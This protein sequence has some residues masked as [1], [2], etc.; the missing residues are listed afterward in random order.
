MKKWEDYLYPNGVLKNKKGIEDF[1][2]LLAYEFAITQISNLQ[3]LYNPIK[4][5]IGFDL[6]KE[7]HN[8]LFCDIYD[9]A[10]KLRDVEIRK[11]VDEPFFT[12]TKLIKKKAEEIFYN[13]KRSNYFL[14][15][16]KEQFII[17]SAEL[18]A[19]LND[20]HPFREGNG[21]TNKL[22]LSY[23]AIINGYQFN[24]NEI[25]QN[26]WIKA[27]AT[28]HTLGDI[29]GLINLLK[30]SI[31]HINDVEYIDKFRK[32]LSLPSNI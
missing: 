2:L 7:M 10:G 22:F 8:Q 24:Y 6:L 30:I 20:L 14:G 4:S 16:S 21:R 15:N 11:S 23:I 3:L 27:S 5:N 18:L 13:L 12:S 26:L 19:K 31:T 29:S 9:W 28:A 25:E 17:H 1:D 32:A